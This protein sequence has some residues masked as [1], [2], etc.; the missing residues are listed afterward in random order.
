MVSMKIAFIGCGKLGQPASE[1]FETYNG[2]SVKVKQP[3]LLILE[4]N[5]LFQDA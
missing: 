3:H 5:Y 1:Y 4:W 2:F